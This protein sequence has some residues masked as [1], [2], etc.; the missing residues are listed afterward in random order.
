MPATVW[1][2]RRYEGQLVAVHLAEDGQ[3]HIVAGWAVAEHH[4]VLKQLGQA[5]D[6]LDGQPVTVRVLLVLWAERLEQML[7][8]VEHGKLLEPCLHVEPWRV[9]NREGFLTRV[10]AA[11]DVIHLVAEAQVLRTP[12]SECAIV[13][14]PFVTVF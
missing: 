12:F 11:G 13:R 4:R 9:A 2:H 14:R 1:P 10:V 8:R 3:H 7:L 5:F 6:L